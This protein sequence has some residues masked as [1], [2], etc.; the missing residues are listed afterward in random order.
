MAAR[1][2]KTANSFEGSLEKLEK[3]V[4]QLEDEEVSIENSL[5]LFGEGKQLVQQCEKELQVVE[6]RVKQLMETPSGEDDEEDFEPADAKVETT[7]GNGG[8]IIAGPPP[9]EEINEKPKAKK[10]DLPF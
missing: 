9:D 10:D 6:N 7:V 4:R 8:V 1:K 2:K 3:I 5:K